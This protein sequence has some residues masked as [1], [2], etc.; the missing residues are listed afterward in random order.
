MSP[1]I[2]KWEYTSVRRVFANTDYEIGTCGTISYENPNFE[3]A[4]AFKVNDHVFCLE[5]KTNPAARP[6]KHQSDWVFAVFHGETHASFGW[7]TD[8]KLTTLI[9]CL[10]GGLSPAFPSSTVSALRGVALNISF[11]SV[12]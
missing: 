4:S 5:R 12:A 7:V 10:V 2:A 11:K 8:G 6:L 3:F 1:I 9:D